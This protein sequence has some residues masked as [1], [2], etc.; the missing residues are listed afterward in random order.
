MLEGLGVFDYGF[1]GLLVVGFVLTAVYNHYKQA[2]KL[3]LEAT[4]KREISRFEL[5]ST[6][7]E[8]YEKEFGRDSIWKRCRASFKLIVA[9]GVAWVALMVILVCT[10]VIAKQ[11]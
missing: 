9:C 4:T 1:G 10:L 2:L 6:L 11:L 5:H 3:R 7:L 8:S